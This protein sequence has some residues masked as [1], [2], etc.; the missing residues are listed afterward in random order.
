ME[1]KKRR[2]GGREGPREEKHTQSFPG[3]MEWVSKKRADI[4]YS[5]FPGLGD[6]EGWGSGAAIFYTHGRVWR[7]NPGDNSGAA[8]WKAAEG[9]WGG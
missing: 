2:R 1:R 9:W 7:C 4:I 6:S 5:F 8:Y 3:E